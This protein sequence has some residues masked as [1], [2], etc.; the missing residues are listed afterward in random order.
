MNLFHF[1]RHKQIILR[2]FCTFHHLGRQTFFTKLMHTEKIRE[3][4]QNDRICVQKMAV[5]SDPIWNWHILIDKTLFK[6]TFITFP[7]WPKMVI[8]F[9]FEF[10]EYQ[11]NWVTATI[12]MILKS[13]ELTI[14]T[15]KFHEF[16]GVVFNFLKLYCNE[17][18]I[19]GVIKIS[20]P[21]SYEINFK[22]G[23]KI[24]H[25]TMPV[26]LCMHKEFVWNNTK[27]ACQSNIK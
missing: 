7:Y 15:W 10:L 23:L 19:E 2:F 3:N 8:I 25:S 20:K 26:M 14:W 17:S 1:W 24:W 11:K 5:G 13:S 18:E 12:I 4:G 21:C 6:K 16:G 9:E 22:N 27:V